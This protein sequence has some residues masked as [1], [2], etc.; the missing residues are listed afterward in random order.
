MTF[1]KEQIVAKMEETGMI[2]VFNHTD[3]QVCKNIIDAA[4]KGGV[5]VFEF[6]NRQPNSPEVF[7]ELVEYVKS[8][9][10]IILGIGTIWNEEE[11]RQFI[12]LGAHFIV[13]PILNDGVA[14]V[15]NL[16][17]T[18]WIPGTATFT[19]VINA[20][21]LG[22]MVMK[23]FPGST[24]GPEYISSLLAVAPT[25]KLM[26]T[27]GVKPTHE[28]LSAWFKAGVI[29]VGMGSQ[30]FNKQLIANGQ[31]DDLTADIAKALEII[32]EL[33]R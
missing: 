8:N 16:H 7:K 22:A 15:C 14:R 21:N 33:D 11:A 27:G 29:C 18:L 12:K 17:N 1:T 30:L 10:E 13:S 31:W 28:N 32:K 19:E 3:L 23:A 25:L 6:T 9:P 4:F 2:P 24:L 5:R 20:K 26:P